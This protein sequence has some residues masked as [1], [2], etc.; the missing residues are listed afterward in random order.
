[1]A[2][3]HAGF[4]LFSVYA[5]HYVRDSSASDEASIASL[6]DI[7]QSIINI[8]VTSAM[9]VS[10]ATLKVNDVKGSLLI[11]G[12]IA[13]SAHITGVAATTM[14]IIAR[15]LR[16]HN[17]KNMVIYL[18]CSSRPIIEDCQEMRFASLPI[19]FVSLSL[20]WMICVT[21]AD[22]QGYQGT[23]DSKK[24]PDLWNQVD[25]FKWLRPEP[26]PNWSVLTPDDNRVIIEDDWKQILDAGPPALGLEERLKLAKL[27]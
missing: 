2:Q 4:K 25:D 1:M 21:I 26:S 22:E 8:S 7:Q 5:T 17:C 24:Q 12:T 9:R 27:K 13:G 18:H 11:C 6:G 23:D 19:I 14:V 15:Q 16:L 10:F 20:R 3:A